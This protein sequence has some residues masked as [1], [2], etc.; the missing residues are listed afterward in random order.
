MGRSATRA[1]FEGKWDRNR[2][3][4]TYKIGKQGVAAFLLFDADDLPGLYLMIG[5]AMRGTNDNTTG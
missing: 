1:T 5:S 3:S 4:V 2:G